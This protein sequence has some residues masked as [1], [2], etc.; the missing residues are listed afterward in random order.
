MI[1]GGNRK[2]YKSGSLTV[3]LINILLHVWNK[4]LEKRVEVSKFQ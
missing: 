1:R 2:D 4:Y 3:P